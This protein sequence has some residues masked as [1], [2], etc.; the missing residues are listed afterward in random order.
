MFLRDVSLVNPRKTFFSSLF[1]IVLGLTILGLRNVEGISVAFIKTQ[2]F[3]YIL[4]VFLII[5]GVFYLFSLAVLMR[6]KIGPALAEF[7]FW[8]TLGILLG[9][10]SSIFPTGLPRICYYVLLAVAL[11][12]SARIVER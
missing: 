2:S 7:F 3:F 5:N 9:S 8:L 6:R 12:T 11:A 10:F 4:C 1:A